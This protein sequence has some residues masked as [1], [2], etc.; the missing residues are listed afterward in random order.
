MK[1]ILIVL[2]LVVALMGC[3]KDDID[4]DIN[5]STVQAVSTVAIAFYLEKNPE[6]VGYVLTL[7]EIVQGLDSNSNS[8]NIAG[9]KQVIFNELKDEDST[10]AK[11]I[12]VVSLVDLLF[13]LAN[14]QLDTGANDLVTP[15][16]LELI[17]GLFSN[18][19]EVAVMYEDK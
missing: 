17:Q 13:N 3:Q 1:K 9:L 4:I 2:A 14:Q 5:N 19:A 11:K 12:A 10:I 16:Y 7:N 8:G 15:E 6:A 18:A